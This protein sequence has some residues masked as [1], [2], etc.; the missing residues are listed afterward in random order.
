MSLIEEETVIRHPC[1]G[2]Q[3]DSLGETSVPIFGPDV[4]V[5]GARV[6]PGASTEPENETDTPVESTMAL[7][8]RRQR[9]I[10]GPFDEWT[11]RGTRWQQ[12]GEGPIWPLGTEIQLGRRTG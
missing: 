7:Y 1:I 3:T 6:A 2:H 11:V 8:F 9:V 10:S 12:E 5:P 4:E